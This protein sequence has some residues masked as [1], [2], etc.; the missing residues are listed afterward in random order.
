MILSYGIFNGGGYADAVLRAIHL[1]EDTDTMGAVTGGLA[2]IY[3]GL[4]E[5][6]QHW[7]TS[8]VRVEDIIELC[9]QFEDSLAK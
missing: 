9:E 1:G 3:Y 8:L 2:G 6:P 7:L 5:I 4:G